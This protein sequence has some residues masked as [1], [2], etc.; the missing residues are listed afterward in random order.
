MTFGN[1]KNKLLIKYNS[2][3]EFGKEWDSLKFFKVLLIGLKIF[4][5]FDSMSYPNIICPTP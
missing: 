2:I 5:I 4:R 1:S 3:W